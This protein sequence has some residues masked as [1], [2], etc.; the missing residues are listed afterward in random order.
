V[1]SEL[2]AADFLKRADEAA[3]FATLLSGRSGGETACGIS[4]DVV[5]PRSE[6]VTSANQR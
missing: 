1:Q 6:W 5:A 4:S 2:I 3:S